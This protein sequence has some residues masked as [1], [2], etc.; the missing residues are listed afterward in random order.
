MLIRTNITINILDNIIET[1][2]FATWYLAI[3]KF[4]MIINMFVNTDA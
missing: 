1:C 3:D 2:K 4:E